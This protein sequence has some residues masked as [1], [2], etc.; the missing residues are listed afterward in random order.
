MI[1]ALH[2]LAFFILYLTSYETQIIGL[3]VLQVIYIV[4]I[5]VLYHIFYKTCNTIVLN[6]MT[7]LLMFGF[8]ILTRL[9]YTKALRQFF[10]CLAGLFICVLIP[11]LLQNITTFRKMTWAYASIGIVGLLSVTLFGSVDYGA[12]LSISLGKIS[13]QPSEFIKIIFVFFLASMLYLKND[14]KQLMFTT[15]FSI[16]FILCLVASKD[17]GGAFLYFVAYLTIVYVATGKFVLFISGVGIMSVAAIGGYA[18][19][20]HVRNR[21]AAWMDPLSVYDTAGYQVSQSLFGIGTGGWFGLG[22]NQGLPGKIPVVDKDFIFSAIAEEMGAIVAICIIM[23]FMSCFLMIMNIALKMKDTFYKLS[24]LGLG[25]IFATQVFLTIGGAVK[26]IPSTGVTLPLI[27]YGG[28]SL[29]STFIIFGVIQGLYM[30]NQVDEQ[31]KG[32]ETIDEAKQT[33]NKKRKSI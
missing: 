28:S 6:N 4:S 15:L 3:Y 27:S 31:E 2:F 19:F 30:K 10:F 33:K 23:V 1:F 32:L 12:K 18:I 29:L 16:A 21:V 20:A 9:S 8:I 7:F 22:L 25:A 5:F 24:A 14:L 26:F 11:I 13:V 17:L